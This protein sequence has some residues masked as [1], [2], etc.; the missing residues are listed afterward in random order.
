MLL[1]DHKLFKTFPY[2]QYA[3]ASH[4]NTF[5]S[6]QSHRWIIASNI[7]HPSHLCAYC[8]GMHHSHNSLFCR[9]VRLLG[10]MENNGPNIMWIRALQNRTALKILL[11]K[12]TRSSI[13]YYAN[14]NAK[15]KKC[16]FRRQTNI[17]NCTVPR[18]KQC[19]YQTPVNNLHE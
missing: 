6:S 9:H 10:N 11:Q 13:F 17:F 15:C 8:V 19:R 2:I 5:A 3:H 12:H 18:N 7:M 16:I 4:S 14:T 1:K